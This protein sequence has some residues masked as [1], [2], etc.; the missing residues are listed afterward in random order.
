MK[1]I[2]LTFKQ[3]LSVFSKFTKV[4]LNQKLNSVV[5]QISIVY[6][7]TIK[8]ILL[9]HQKYHTSFLKRYLSQERAFLNESIIKPKEGKENHLAAVYIFLFMENVFLNVQG[10]DC[11][12]PGTQRNRI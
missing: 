11:D 1:N 8:S 2:L 10:N 5:R 7:K 12:A 4:K 9:C 3:K 6:V